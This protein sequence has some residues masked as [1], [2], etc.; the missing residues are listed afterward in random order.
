MQTQTHKNL[1]LTIQNDQGDFVKREM[2]EQEAIIFF[3]NQY[4]HH[5]YSLDHFPDLLLGNHCYVQ[6][7]NLWMHPLRYLS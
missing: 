1:I 7:F 3:S 4:W 6:P 2:L 5:P